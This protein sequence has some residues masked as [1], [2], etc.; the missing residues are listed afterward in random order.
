M[1]LYL[2]ILGVFAFGLYSFSMFVAKH[3]NVLRYTQAEHLSPTGSMQANRAVHTATL[4]PDGRVLVVG[5]CTSHG[6]EA[7]DDAIKAELYNTT[8]GLFS[9]AGSM[10]D[11]RASGHTATFIGQGQ[12]LI[13]G[14][15]RSRRPTSSAEVYHI[16]SGV[17]EKVHAMQAARTGHTATALADGRIL[18][19]GGDNGKETLAS[20]EIFDPVTHTFTPAASL[21]APRAGHVAIRLQDGRVLAIGGHDYHNKLV[22]DTAEIYDPAS[23]R[24]EPAGNLT[25]VRHKHGA[26]LLPDGR[27]LVVGG[28]NERDFRGRYNHTEI[29]NPDTDTF[30]RAAQM[31]SP[32]F[33]LPNAIVQLLNGEILVA[34]GDEWAEVYN[35]KTNAFRQIKGSM[36]SKRSFSAATLLQDG[37]ALISGG[38]DDRIQLTN[39]A[40]LYAH[41]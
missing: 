5:G 39:Q 7:G 2:Q 6:C 41:E 34:G 28:S 22:L 11:E 10:K 9:P 3:D 33:K 32:R 13:S 40:W 17:F 29:Y 8:T 30:E 4:L 19:I 38:Y 20:V 31:K 15:W 18:I 12:V 21:N 25:M 23:G 37:R 26:A 27:V 36:G 16:D 24:F 1:K 14:G 35:P